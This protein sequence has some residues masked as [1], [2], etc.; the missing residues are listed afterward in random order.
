MG[1][2]LYDWEAEDA[3]RTCC[4]PKI[5]SPGNYAEKFHILLDHIFDTER[6]IRE[7]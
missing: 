5:D 7:A 1:K 2:R 4:G 3:P 6:I